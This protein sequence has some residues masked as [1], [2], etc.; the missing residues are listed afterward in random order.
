[1]QMDNR[2]ILAGVA[3]DIGR[4]MA[5]GV[6]LADMVRESQTRN[7]LTDLYQQQG[8]GIAAGDSGAL[9]ALAGIDPM[10]ALGVQ[11]KRLGM[12]ST[13]QVMRI[14][15]EQLRMAY[16]ETKQRAAM[17]AAQ[18]SAQERAAEA[19]KLERGLAALTAAQTPEQ[20]DAFAAENQPELVGKFWQKEMLFAQAAGMKEALELRQGAKPLS[21]LGKFEADRAAGLLPPGAE[22]KPDGGTNVTV[23]TGEGSKFYDELDKGQATMFQSLLNDGVQAGRTLQ[24]VGRLAEMLESV[25]TGGAAAVKTFLGEYGISTE[26]LSELQ[27]L[28]ALINQIVP[29]QRQPGSGPMSD[30]DLALFKQSVPRLINQPGGNRIIV[31]RMRGIAQY[32]M[33]QAEIAARVA[34]RSMTPAQG[35]QE[36][37]SL[38]NPLEGFGAGAADAPPAQPQ[39]PAGN[40]GGVNWRI[41]E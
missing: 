33:Q 6:G 13:R 25:P 14:N 12:D 24:Q 10:A 37:A 35:R 17:Q 20:W 28:Q 5:Q 7:R 39:A 4:S 26:G 19:A 36:L 40:A 27:S 18:M 2:V 22:F 41:V 16:A 38:V 9:N 23:N 11:D 34:D 8:A 15:E 3:P 31:D 1:M 21:P 32:Q 30:A 29:Q